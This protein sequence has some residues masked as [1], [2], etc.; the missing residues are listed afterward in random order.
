MKGFLIGCWI[1]IFFFLLLLGRHN[2]REREGHSGSI[3]GI[4]WIAS[5]LYSNESLGLLEVRVDQYIQIWHHS[6]DLE[7]KSSY[8]V[9]L[10]GAGDKA[11]WIFHIFGNLKVHDS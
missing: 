11:L 5:T 8:D 2:W 1:L 7:V 3:Y 9:W 6:A 4:I 10:N